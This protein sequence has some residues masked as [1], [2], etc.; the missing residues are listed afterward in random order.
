MKGFHLLEL[1]HICWIWPALVEKLQLKSKIKKAIPLSWK[2]FGKDKS[3][4]TLKITQ[5]RAEL[6][7]LII[8][9]ILELIIIKYQWNKSWLRQMNF[10]PIPTGTQNT[11][12][13]IISPLFFQLQYW[14]FFIKIRGGG[15]LYRAGLKWN[16][17]GVH[18]SWILVI[19]LLNNY[20]CITLWWLKA[21]SNISR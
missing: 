17:S 3:E 7:N 16:T 1:K 2:I 21:H 4:F 10:Q 13:C 11:N 8:G 9:S 20:I 14:L 12:I 18:E 6:T 15:R 19:I 5:N